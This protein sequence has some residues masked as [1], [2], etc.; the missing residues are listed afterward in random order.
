MRP[1]HSGSLRLFR[2]AGIQVFVHWS[3]FLLIVYEVSTRRLSYSSPAWIVAETVATFAIVTMHEFGHSLACRQVGGQ[4]QDIILWPL[5]GVAYVAPP[6]RPGAMLWSIAAGPL[7]NVIL[8][9]ILGAI[10][11]GLAYAGVPDTS[12]DLW[13]FVIAMNV[14]N[15]VLLVFNLLPVYPL[16]GGQ[17]L[18][19]LL[20]YGVG[21]AR[22][23]Q[24]ASVIGI[25]GIVIGV[26]WRFSANPSTDSLVWDALIAFFLGQRCWMGLREAKFITALER[27]PRHAGFACPSCHLAPPGGPIWA[28]RQCRRPFDPFSTNAVCP[29]CGTAHPTTVCVHCGARHPIAEWRTAEPPPL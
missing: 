10:Y 15:F 11:Y 5:G 16:D 9:P 29:H 8:I 21:R 3:W 24:I 20:W 12:L 19:S 26:L 27:A 22:S 23:L 28:C 1:T 4:T 14:I 6:P 18:R 13:H 17:I 7:V 2:F 25:A